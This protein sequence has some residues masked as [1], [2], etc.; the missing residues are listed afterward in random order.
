MPSLLIDDLDPALHQRLLERAAAHHRAP[1]AG[2]TDLLGL[3]RHLFGPAHGVTLDLPARDP[4]Q[5]RPP[6]DFGATTG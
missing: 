1:A 2:A 5:D 4:A 6:P 3:A